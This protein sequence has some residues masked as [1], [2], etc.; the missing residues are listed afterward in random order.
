VFVGSAEKNFRVSEGG[1]ASN[2]DPGF[3]FALHTPDRTFHFS[4]DSEQERKEWIEVLL[5][6]ISN[7]LSPQDSKILYRSTSI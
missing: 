3:G 5:Y 6:V 4:A 2:K 7:P 1:T